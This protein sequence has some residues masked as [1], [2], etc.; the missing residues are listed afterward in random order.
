MSLA[1][2][3]FCA[4]LRCAPVVCYSSSVLNSHLHDGCTITVQCRLKHSFSL[5]F[6]LSFLSS[7]FFLSSSLLPP[8]FLPSSSL[9][10]PFFLPSSSL[11]PPLGSL[12]SWFSLLWFS[13]L[14]FPLPF[15][16]SL[17]FFPLPLFFSSHPFFPLSLFFLERFPSG[18][19]AQG[20][21]AQDEQHI[22]VQQLDEAEL[23]VDNT[24]RL[25][26]VPHPDD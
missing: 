1:S 20:T 7:F 12:P 4:L 22:N 18:Q 15:F 14:F 3:A 16:S 19:G 21:V 25:D 10:P 8:F 13:H 2:E 5:S 23:A 17:P 9:L 11:L 6:S 24:W 26:V